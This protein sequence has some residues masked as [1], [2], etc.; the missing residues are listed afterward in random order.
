VRSTWSSAE[1]R[2]IHLVVDRLRL[3]QERW[4]PEVTIADIEHIS[5]HLRELL[6]GR[7]YIKA[8]NLLAPVEPMRSPNMVAPDL[9]ILAPKDRYDWSRIGF[10]QTAGLETPGIHWWMPLGLMKGAEIGQRDEV[11]SKRRVEI[12]RAERVK[13]DQIDETRDEI[14]SHTKLAPRGARMSGLIDQGKVPVGAGSSYKRYKL[15]KYLDSI[16]LIHMGRPF[17]RAELVKNYANKY[18]GIHI[19]WTESGE[20]HRAMAEAGAGVTISDRNPVLYELLSIGQTLA[21]SAD[22]LILRNAADA[23]GLS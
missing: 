12:F 9:E 22:A 14:V 4:G 2:G 21:N 20:E 11:G 7:D 23:A 13:A 8:W 16:C 6:P 15:S 10:A 17:T 3:I 5:G 19:E 18:G 1:R